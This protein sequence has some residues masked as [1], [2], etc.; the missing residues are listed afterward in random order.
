MLTLLSGPGLI[1]RATILRKYWD[2]VVRRNKNLKENLF[3]AL[4][5]LVGIIYSLH[6]RI[7]DAL[8]LVT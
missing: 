6:K 8:K 7:S 5:L 1:Y 4:F 2:R 3:W